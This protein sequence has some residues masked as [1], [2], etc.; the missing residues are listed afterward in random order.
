MYM[1]Y[2]LS[3]KSRAK[4]PASW[5]SYCYFL[6]MTRGV[7]WPVCQCVSCL[8][9]C[10][11]SQCHDKKSALSLVYFPWYVLIIITLP[12]ICSCYHNIAHMFLL[13][14]HFPRYVF[15]IRTLPMICYWCHDI[16]HHMF[17]LSRHFPV[18]SVCQKVS[19]EGKSV[20]YFWWQQRDLFVSWFLSRRLRYSFLSNKFSKFLWRTACL[21]PLNDLVVFC[22]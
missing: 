5:T 17:I 19:M 15:V 4:Y 11:V 7:G 8:A 16:S 12:M 2:S 6:A 9:Y 3:N 13:S 14:R 20:V 10:Q 18:D 21:H 22:V 1:S